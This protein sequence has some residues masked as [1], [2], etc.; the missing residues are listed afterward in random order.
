MSKKT[1]FMKSY[2]KATG[3]DP[4]K[5]DRTDKDQVKEFVSNLEKH[6]LVSSFR[7]AVQETQA[8]DDAPFEEIAMMGMAGLFENI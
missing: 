5:V 4:A 6:H 2:K 8:S 3:Q 1:E 7:E